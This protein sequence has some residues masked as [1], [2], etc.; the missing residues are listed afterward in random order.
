MIITINRNHISF[1]NLELNFVIFSNESTELNMLFLL[2]I[3]LGSITHIS[4]AGNLPESF[5]CIC[6]QRREGKRNIKV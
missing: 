2:E 6:H 4:V 3:S 5:L 1:T